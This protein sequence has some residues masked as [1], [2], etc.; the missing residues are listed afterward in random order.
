M[1]TM[2]SYFHR[3]RAGLEKLVQKCESFALS[4]DIKFNV[5]K[6][7]CMIFNPQRP[8]A[9]SHLTDSQPP[10]IMLNGNSLSWVSHFK[11]LGHM[12]DCNLGDSIDMRRIKRSLYYSTNMIYTLLSHAGTGLLM[13]LFQ[14]YC[15]NLYGCELW[16]ITRETRAFRE[17][18]VAYHSCVKKLARVPK[19]FRNHP[20]CLAL[21]V[22]PCPMLIATRQI[23]FYKRL[24]SSKNT[25]IEAMIAGSIRHG[26]LLGKC[27]LAIRERYD[28]MS[29]DL[30][31]ASRA[32]IMNVFHSCLMRKV[33]DRN[34]TDVQAAHRR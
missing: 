16:D 2:L 24:L 29:L 21:K 26:T 6:T 32:S 25:I 23:M 1:L 10:S 20:L 19:T 14:T 18:C 31:N 30:S 9:V 13:K 28:L 15:T 22:L 4:R 5:K 3:P 27:H 33:N 11:Y 34:R 12:L 8:Y 7:V 17:L